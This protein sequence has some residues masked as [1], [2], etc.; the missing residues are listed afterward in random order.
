MPNAAITTQIHQTFDVHGCLPTQITFDD[1]IRNRAANA[2]D[3]GFRKVFHLRVWR[4]ARHFANLLRARIS[5]PIDRGLR[6]HD[7][8][9]NGN[10][11]ACYTSHN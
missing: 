8:L 4:N 3:L 9:V 6:N 7:V 10:I 11:Y 1:E 2:C 5:N